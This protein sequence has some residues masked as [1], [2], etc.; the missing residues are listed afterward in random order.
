MA[1]P[2]FQPVVS[3]QWC[4][5][6]GVQP[7]SSPTCLSFTVSP[8]VYGGYA[9]AY[10][11]YSSS[12]KPY[13][14]ASSSNLS[15]PVYGS[16]SLARSKPTRWILP[17]R[18]GSSTSYWGSLLCSVRMYSRSRGCGAV[19]LKREEREY[20]PG[21]GCVQSRYVLCRK[22]QPRVCVVTVLL[23]SCTTQSYS[24][25]QARFV[26]VGSTDRL[27]LGSSVPVWMGMEG[28]ILA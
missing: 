19:P 22:N 3:S 18:H 11:L 26:T 13:L 27:P 8:L 10:T 24:P 20:L 1:V 23:S 9:P 12:R 21:T 14:Y 4:P 16:N 6:S 25:C 17:L 2:A 7:G 5:A 28:S 15:T